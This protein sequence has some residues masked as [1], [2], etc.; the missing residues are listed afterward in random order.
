MQLFQAH[1]WPYYTVW[2]SPLT[3]EDRRKLHERVWG[4]F[5]E[6]RKQTFL[7]LQSFGFC[8]VYCT[9]FPRVSTMGAVAGFS[10]TVWKQHQQILIEYSRICLYHHTPV[11]QTYV[12]LA[13]HGC[14]GLVCFLPIGV[15]TLSWKRLHLM[16]NEVVREG[17]LE[18]KE[19]GKKR[20]GWRK[21]GKKRRVYL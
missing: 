16:S 5:L 3:W 10:D 19:R 6:P 4:V 15:S 14:Q 7:V 12:T 11:D 17:Y 1:E 2:R 21:K 20:L 8:W 18:V 13:S 9:P